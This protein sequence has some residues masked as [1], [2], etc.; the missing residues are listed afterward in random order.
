VAEIRAAA[1]AATDVIGTPGWHRLRHPA[2]LA[3][4]D[5]ALEGWDATRAMLS[6]TR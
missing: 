6:A 2:A 1:P 3:R 4:L 5:P